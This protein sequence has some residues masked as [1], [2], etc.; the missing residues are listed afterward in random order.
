MPSIVATLIQIKV[1]GVENC[2]SWKVYII[3]LI[4]ICTTSLQCIII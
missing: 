4:H 2:V 3:I 1:L